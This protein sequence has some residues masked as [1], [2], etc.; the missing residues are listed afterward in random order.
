MSLSAI[1]RNVDDVDLTGFISVLH[2]PVMTSADAL[3][4]Y[5]TPAEVVN[6]YEA[7]AVKRI[8]VFYDG[9]HRVV[10]SLAN[11]N[12]ERD[13]LF[14]NADGMLPVSLEDWTVAN[15]SNDLGD[16]QLGKRFRLIAETLTDWGA[17]VDGRPVINRVYA[18]YTG[19]HADSVSIMSNFSYERRK[20]VKGGDYFSPASLGVVLP[21]ANAETQESGS[22]AA[23]GSK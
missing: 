17:G 5:S 13:I 19:R 7:F 15:G 8:E 9:S 3:Y 12:M 10:W 11:G 21:A 22:K 18:K 23:V 16:R 2:M 1:G 14:S 20:P 4:G 6:A